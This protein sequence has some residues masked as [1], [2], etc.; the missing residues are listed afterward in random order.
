MTRSRRDGG[1]RGPTDP[2]EDDAIPELWPGKRTGT[3]PVSDERPPKW[4]GKRS[5]TQRFR[6]KAVAPR[7]IDDVATAAIEEKGAGRPVDA[8]V[9]GEIEPHLGTDLSS[10]RV[11]DDAQAQQASHEMGARAFAHGADIF[12]GPGESDRDVGLMAHELTHV[13]QQG[14]TPTPQRKVTV[15]AANTP[16]EAEADAVS[17]RVTGG[18]APSTRL[19]D[20]GPVGTG[21]MQKLAFLDK[22]QAAVIAEAIR[23]LGTFGSATECPY[24]L[25]TFAK[26]RALPA[27]AS[28]ELMHRWIPPARDARSAEDLIPLVVGR[29]RSGVRGWRASGRLPEDLAAAEPALVAAAAPGAASHAKG[30]ETLGGL[31]AQLG[32]GAPVDSRIAAQMSRATG[33]DVSG[34]RVHT[35]A[36]AAAKA[37]ERDATAFAVGQHI[38][39]G[40]GAPSAGTDF[41]DALLAH[42]LA[43]TA[44]QKDAAQDPAARKKP[45]EQYAHKGKQRPNNPPVGSLGVVSVPC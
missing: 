32:P 40:A 13:V 30:T 14:A 25:E 28:T 22:L 9:R 26:Y 5:G 41:G 2:G 23:E 1:G 24:I 3:M 7:T 16:A 37:A 21:Q 35:G 19:V 10:T 42:E 20:T 12:L 27:T 17:S 43:H 31:E 39:M 45:I 6:K 15:G 44:Q 8:G 11:H 29:V 38:V 18:A 34:A 4:P 36:V 33:Q